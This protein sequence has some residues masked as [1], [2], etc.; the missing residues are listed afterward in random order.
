MV[1]TIFGPVCFQ[2]RDGFLSLMK[3]RVENLVRRHGEKVVVMTHSYG[4]NVF[5]YFL[6]YGILV[7][8]ELLDEN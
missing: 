1:I 7:F 4:S 5:F 3:A 2:K 6:K 8:V